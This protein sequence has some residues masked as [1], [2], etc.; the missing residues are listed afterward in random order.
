MDLEIIS[1][2]IFFCSIIVFDINYICYKLL[3]KILLKKEEFM[4]HPKYAIFVVILFSFN[5]FAGAWTQEKNSGFYKFGARYISATNIYDKDGNKI[6]IPKLTNLFLA[7]YGEYGINDQLTVIAN[8]SVLESIKIDDSALLKGDSNSGIA[9]SELGIRYK[10]WQGDFSV[11]STELFFGLPIGDTDNALGLYTG[12]GE[13]NQNLSI[14]YGQSFYP[15]PLYFSIQAGFNNRTAGF[16]DEIR[17]AAEVGFN[18]IPNILFALKIHGIQSIENGSENIIG[19]R[20]GFHS[21]NQTYLA[22][23][24]EIIYAFTKS[25]GISVGFESATN[26]ANVPSALA[27][28]FGIYFKN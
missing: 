13:F 19:G 6:D 10:I 18:F 15:L 4:K 12:D 2:S 25:F 27:Y 3:Y 8:L 9:D 5:V 22:F 20:Y 23:G 28:S 1:E 16:S 26:A 14:L 17:Y 24:P 21:N 11:L 7:L